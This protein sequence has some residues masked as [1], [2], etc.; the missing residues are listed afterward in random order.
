MVSEAILAQSLVN[1]N[2]FVTVVMTEIWKLT[3]GYVWIFSLNSE[4]TTKKKKIRG[5]HAFPLLM[6]QGRKYLTVSLQNRDKI[7][8]LQNDPFCI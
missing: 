6:C 5:S 3:F 1:I 7:I 4:W 8:K 2:S